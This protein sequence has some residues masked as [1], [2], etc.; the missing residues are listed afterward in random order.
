[1]KKKLTT[2]EAACI[3]TGYGLGAGVLS[4]P[5]LARQNG[6]LVSFLILTVSLI[7][8]YLLHLMI[9]ELAIRNGG[10]GQVISCLSRFL[11]RG[12]YK[13]LLT[14]IFFVLMAGILLTNL[15]AYI[16]GA[17]EVIV[18]LLPVSEL[19]AKLLFYAVAALVV[20]FGLKAVGVSE[21]IAVGVI[22]GMI[23]VLGIASLL[24]IRNPLPMEVGT[25]S[26]ALAYYGMAMF[27]MAAFFSVPQ[28]VEGLSGDVKA[29][30]KAV[31]L[32]LFNNY[33]LILVVTVCSLLASTEITEVAMV[34]WS[35][36]IGLWAQIIGSVFTILAMLTTYWS[37]SLALGGMVQDML[38]IND[39]LG[40]LLATL[41]SFVLALVNL[42]SFLS[43]M[44][45][46][47]GLIAI[48]VSLM[49]VPAYRNAC[50]ETSGTP[51][52]SRSGSE[53]QIAVILAYLLM[54]V[55]SVVP[56]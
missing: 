47:G 41:P 17:A 3:I 38:R 21:T 40:W 45:T 11:L 25:T 22:F 1:M 34:G 44:R 19:A 18:G 35:Q 8:S 2:W 6:V 36:G 51:L 33:I 23:A 20:L 27:A 9:A 5:Y 49:V 12:K 56:V 15:A 42:S 50:R 54:A 32:G 30:K 4:M 55:G 48:V 14:G 10:S 26:Q 13:N 7:A 46:A 29:I 31:F 39:R 24:H 28:A 16:T 43:L 37:L 53:L 52:I